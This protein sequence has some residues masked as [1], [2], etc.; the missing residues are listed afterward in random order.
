MCLYA[1][2][3]AKTSAISQQEKEQDNVHPSVAAEN[4]VEVSLLDNQAKESQQ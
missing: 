3:L 1:P 2:E 4:T